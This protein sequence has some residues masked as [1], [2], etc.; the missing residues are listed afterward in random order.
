[1]KT[2]DSDGNVRKVLLPKKSTIL[3]EYLKSIEFPSM[4]QEPLEFK[5]IVFQSKVCAKMDRRTRMARSTMKFDTSD[6][7]YC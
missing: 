6:L 5:F 1:M 3:K 4:E 2:K 7:R